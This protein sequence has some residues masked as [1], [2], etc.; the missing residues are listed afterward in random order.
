LLDFGLMWAARTLEGYVR[1]R[2]GLNQDIPKC[3]MHVSI[4]IVG[5]D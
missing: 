5:V 3:L 2:Q 4:R 1:C